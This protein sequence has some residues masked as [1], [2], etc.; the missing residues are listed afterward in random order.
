MAERVKNHEVS[1]SIKGDTAFEEGITEE[2]Q[3]YR[4]KNPDS[5]T[6]KI[7]LEGK[8]MQK[9][10]LGRSPD[11]SDAF[12]FRAYF[13]L[14]KTFHSISDAEINIGLAEQM[15]WNEDFDPFDVV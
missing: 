14:R 3:T 9:Q 15:A 8:E 12:I 10:T 5:D 13:A 2:L 6:V 7:S 11:L 4:I 1:I